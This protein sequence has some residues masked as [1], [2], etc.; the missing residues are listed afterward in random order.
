MWTVEHEQRWQDQILSERARR[1]ARPVDARRDG[2]PVGTFAL[3]RVGDLRIGLPTTGV[4]A[5]VPTPPISLLPGLPAFMPGI[6]QIRG[7]PLSIV[8]L[9]RL[10]ALATATHQPLDAVLQGPPGRLGALV[11]RVDGF[12]TVYIE[13][14]AGS[15]RLTTDLPVLGIT[16]D[17]VHMLDVDTL[18]ADP[19][20]E[21]RADSPDAPH[22][23]ARSEPSQGA[24]E[25]PSRGDK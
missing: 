6:A 12:R 5:I 23:S 21:V 19:R 22:L 24:V 25:V 3:V 9:R 18:L 2:Q 7:E 15:K 11:D 20:I 1:A 17:L 10:Y 13:E 8:D 16:Q 4:R 14:L